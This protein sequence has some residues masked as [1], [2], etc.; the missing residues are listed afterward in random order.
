MLSTYWAHWPV[1]FTVLVV[2][3]CYVV[4]RAREMCTHMGHFHCCLTATCCLSWLYIV[5][6][7][8]HSSTSE[9]Q[10]RRTRPR[11]LCYLATGWALNLPRAQPSDRNRRLCS[12]YTWDKDASM[13]H[14]LQLRLEYSIEV[15][16]LSPRAGWTTCLTGMTTEVNWFLHIHSGV[17]GELW[18]G[19]RHKLLEI[20]NITGHQ[21]R[22][23]QMGT[24]FWWLSIC[25]GL[26][27]T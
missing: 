13:L 5:Q 10:V 11:V 3:L 8:L 22:V 9:Q 2:D 19:Q 7:K 27:H 6:W 23:K 25:A 18:G 17:C 26:P 15:C 21:S 20:F 1:H 12:Q 24:I 4:S 16:H 14:K